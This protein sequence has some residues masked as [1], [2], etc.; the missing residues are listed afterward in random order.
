MAPKTSRGQW[1]AWVER[2]ETRRTRAGGFERFF[3]HEDVSNA[4]SP[5]EERLTSLRATLADVDPPV[6]NRRGREPAR[7]V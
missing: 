3:A 2:S 7:T 6:G 1:V 4:L 5:H